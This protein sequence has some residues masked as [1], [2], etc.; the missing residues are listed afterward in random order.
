MVGTVD[1]WP[2][3]G[4]R[5]F[6]WRSIYC[7]DSRLVFAFCHCIVSA[8]DRNYLTFTVSKYEFPRTCVCRGWLP[9]GHTPTRA[10]SY[11]G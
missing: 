3:L 9:F 5:V 2:K 6:F 10:V 4:L 11:A 8:F 1:V 7:V